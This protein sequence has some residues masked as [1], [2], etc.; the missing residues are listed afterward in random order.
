MRHGIIIFPIWLYGSC[1]PFIKYEILNIA[2]IEIHPYICFLQI[3][4]LNFTQMKIQVY[5]LLNEILFF[6]F[7]RWQPIHH[8]YHMKYAI[9][10]I[11]H[12][13]M[14]AWVSYVKYGNVNTSVS[15][16]FQQELWSSMLQIWK[17]GEDF[18]LNMKWFVLNIWDSAK[19]LW[20][21]LRSFLH[22]T[23]ESLSVHYPT[24]NTE[25]C[26]I[27][28]LKS[29]HRFLQWYMEF[30]VFPYEYFDTNCPKWKMEIYI[31]HIKKIWLHI[32]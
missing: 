26:V 24:W 11:L 32:K 13:K 20:H 3:S 5:I 29:K 27:H 28:I 15:E 19:A 4:I 18:I 23:Y 1:F 2:Y 7:S 8:F 25:P 31:H 21:K 10:F 17:S 6:L 9:L 14:R 16:F 12:M 30:S 22:F